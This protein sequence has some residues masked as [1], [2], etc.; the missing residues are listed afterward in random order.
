MAFRKG[1]TICFP[2]MLVKSQRIIM[3]RLLFKTYH[4]LTKA[5][6]RWAQNLGCNSKVIGNTKL[7]FK[8]LTLRTMAFLLNQ[9]NPLANTGLQIT[10][11][12]GPLKTNSNKMFLQI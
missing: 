9:D 7:R 10:S 1:I 4:H 2:K 6:R 8:T 12:R 11:R 3:D 5:T